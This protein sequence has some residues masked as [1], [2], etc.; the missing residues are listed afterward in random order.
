MIQLPEVCPECQAPT[1]LSQDA[2][3]GIKQLY[4]TNLQCPGRLR[5]DLVV[6]SGRDC[7]ELDGLGPELAAQLVEL[8][9]VTDLADLFEFGLECRTQREENQEKYEASLKRVGV[10]VAAMNKLAASVYEARTR[11]WDRWIMALNVEGIG[12]TLGKQLVQALDIQGIDELCTKLLLV[13]KL[14]LEGFGD[15]KVEQVARWAS[16]PFNQ[17]ICGRLAHLGVAPKGYKRIQVSENTAQPCAGMTICITGEHLGMD[18]EVIGQ[19]LAAMGAVMKSGVSKKCSH[20]LVGV[21]AGRSKLTKAD[22]LGIVRLSTGWLK[23][24]FTK[25]S[26]VTDNSDFELDVE[27]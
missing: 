13:G 7:L 16:E 25:H 10:S 23:E 21:G 19:H 18:R 26:I 22:E 15:K 14:G 11:D 3:S 2:K 4:C 1:R 8:D 20:L 9:L 6:L 12:K 17:D 24:L 5:E 27:I